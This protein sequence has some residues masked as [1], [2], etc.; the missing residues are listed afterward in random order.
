MAH[1]NTQS[2]LA[3]LHSAAEISEEKLSKMVGSRLSTVVEYA[4]IMALI[5]HIIGIIGSV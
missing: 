4:L 1:M 5:A 3:V 2:F